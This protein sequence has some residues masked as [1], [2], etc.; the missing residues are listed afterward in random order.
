MYYLGAEQCDDWERRMSS[1][2]FTCQPEERILYVVVAPIVA[3]KFIIWLG[4]CCEG[5]EERGHSECIFFLKHFVELCDA[6]FITFIVLFITCKL[7]RK[8]LHREQS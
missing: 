8:N 7:C 2:F 4:F 1:F 5:F 6:T 3:E